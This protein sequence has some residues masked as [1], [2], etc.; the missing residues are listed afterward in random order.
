MA[1]RPASEPQTSA[2]RSDLSARRAEVAAVLADHG[3]R[4]A[5]AAFAPEH[6]MRHGMVRVGGQRVVAFQHLIA[7][8]F[9]RLP[10]VYSRL[11]LP[12]PGQR[13]AAPLREQTRWNLA[14]FGIEKAAPVQDLLDRVGDGR[15][16]GVVP[17]RDAPAVE[18]LR[19]AVAH[20]AAIP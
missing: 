10:M 7:G 19:F 3:I 18:A 20:L 17:K 6:G 14:P 1:R 5:R 8:T 2:A 13:A 16:F 15:D 11:R 9:R 4:P 12:R